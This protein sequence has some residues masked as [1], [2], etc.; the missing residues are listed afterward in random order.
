MTDETC[1]V[2]GQPVGKQTR[3]GHRRREVKKV[4]KRYVAEF[5]FCP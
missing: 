4:G 5:R 2:S 1:G 3:F